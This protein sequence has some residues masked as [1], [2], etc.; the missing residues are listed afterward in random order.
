MVS[1]VYDTLLLIIQYDLLPGLR[2]VRGKALGLYELHHEAEI[3]NSKE[4]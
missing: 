4:I 3:K 2:D 1:I